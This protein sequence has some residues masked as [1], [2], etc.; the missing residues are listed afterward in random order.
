MKGLRHA[1][2]FFC[3]IF[4][5]AIFASRLFGQTMELDTDRPGMDYKSFDLSLPDP[6]I[7]ENACK[8]D[9]QN[10][11]VW[12]YVKPGIQGPQARCWLKSGFPTAVKNNCCVSGVMQSLPIAERR[13]P[14]KGQIVSPMAP[15]LV[16]SYLQPDLMVKDIAIIEDC[17]LQFTL[18]NIG[19][20]GVTQNIKVAYGSPDKPNIKAADFM[21]GN[22]K[23]PDGEQT[24]VFEWVSQGLPGWATFPVPTQL[25]VEVNPD[26][27]VVESNYT[28]N[29]FTKGV[30]CLPDLIIKDMGVVQGCSVQLV[31]K[32]IGIAYF[33][34]WVRVHFYDLSAGKYLFSDMPVDLRPGAEKTF[35]ISAWVIGNKPTSVKLTVG[36]IPNN[37]Y[38]AFS[39]SN[40]SNNSLTKTLQCGP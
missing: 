33:A 2:I 24:Y 19:K 15:A 3:G 5:I 13:M 22:L 37:P 23:T 17:K 21:P 9:P 35:V 11:K 7:C 10:C 39:E 36:P 16:K 26:K 6:K 8:E 34:K 20:I 38:Q 40:P 12:T 27:S 28:N 32:N 18:K 31:L 4:A 1:G 30:K 25:R 29:S 14:Q